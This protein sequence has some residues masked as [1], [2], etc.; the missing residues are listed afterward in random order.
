MQKLQLQC[1]EVQYPAQR[2]SWKIWWLPIEDIVRYVYFKMQNRLKSNFNRCILK[3][4]SNLK[5]IT[6]FTNRLHQMRVYQ[7]HECE[8]SRISLLI[9]LCYFSAPT[10]QCHDLLK[11]FPGWPSSTITAF[12][13]QGRARLLGDLS[14]LAAPTDLFKSILEKPFTH[15][16]NPTHFR[17]KERG[18]SVARVWLDE[19]PSRD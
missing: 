1:T 13:S 5:I 3:L 11:E 15:F 19:G 10:L 8:P 17:L 12:K 14:R 9:H 6:H 2:Q 4:Y 16:V 18:I 7:N